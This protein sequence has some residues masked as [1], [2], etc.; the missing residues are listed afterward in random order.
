HT[1][2]VFAV[3]FA[4]DGKTLA[5]ASADG[6]LRV[7]DPTGE[8]TKARAVIEEAHNKKEVSCLTYSPAD[9]RVL[10][11]GSYDGTIKLWDLL[12]FKPGQRSEVKTAA[13][14]VQALTFTPSGK[15]MASA[16]SDG[17]LRLWDATVVQPKERAVLEGHAG[18]AAGVAF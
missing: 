10:A 3:G 5:S 15:T 9:S 6:S 16:H 4:P 2:A 8:D 17:S 11:T 14:Y 12:N 18:A 13:G 1:G 7:W